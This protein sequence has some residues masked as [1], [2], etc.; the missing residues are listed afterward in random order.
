MAPL[1]GRE[2]EVADLLLQG[3]SNK[4]MALAL[5]ISDRTVEFHLKNIYAKLQ[6]RSRTE[7]VLKLGKSTGV[8]PVVSTVVG[9]GENTDNDGNPIPTRR[10]PMK[11]LLYG[12]GGLLITTLMVVLVLANLPARGAP[13]VLAPAAR[14]TLPPPTATASLTPQPTVSAKTH[15]LEQIRQ[16]VLE[17]EQNVQ[18][19]KKN[20]TV[21]YSKD[22]QTGE[23][24][25]RFTGDSYER[26]IGL[27]EKLW[28]TINQL[29]AL[30]VQVYRDETRP[31]PF[32]TQVSAA[33]NKAYYEKLLTQS[34][35]ECG[36]APYTAESASTFS[37]YSP[38]DGKE[39]SM[40]V[41]DRSAGCEVL[42]QMIDEFRIAP[43][44]SKVN[45]SAD[46]TLIRQIMGKPNMEL[47]FQSVSGPANSPWRN[48]AIYTDETGT[49]YYVDADN[50]RLAQIEPGGLS[51]PDIPAS[52]AKSTDEL[53][54]IARQFAQTN[55]PNLSKLLSVLS[56]QEGG[57]GD[58][59][60]FT[61]TYN[62]K[63]W[64][65]TDWAM[66][67]PFLQVGVLTNGQIYTYI[68]TLDLYK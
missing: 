55:S 34:G 13:A 48:A 58:I 36:N 44:L 6:V 42:G 63:D 38:N 22:P 40:V 12:I 60:F 37:I 8:Q 66:M 21:E 45:Q 43:I 25:F 33:E 3:K 26:I 35:D 2:T 23:D 57:K 28:G 11:N 68:N 31:T 10:L 49:K 20:G 62:S 18:A 52:Q 7:A 54:G 61:W 1:S 67:P 32:P 39:L 41:D 65:G 27:N 30:Y 9:T 14:P 4:E 24:L 56:Y 5:G 53:R 16:A 59:Y 46:I 19:E 17:Y 51:H 47:A 15:I 50:A 64:S 29:D